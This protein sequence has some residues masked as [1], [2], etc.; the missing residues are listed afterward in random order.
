M[1]QNTHNITRWNDIAKNPRN[2][3]A[4]LNLFTLFYMPQ[5]TYKIWIFLDKPFEILLWL[6]WAT[7]RISWPYKILILTQHVSSQISFW[8]KK[9]QECFTR[10]MWSFCHR[11]G[12]KQARKLYETATFVNHFLEEWCTYLLHNCLEFYSRN[13]SFMRLYLHDSS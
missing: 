10:F 2:I 11:V 7:E 8:I 1:R 4:P 12:F 13:W 5:Q 6:L 3:F 9:G